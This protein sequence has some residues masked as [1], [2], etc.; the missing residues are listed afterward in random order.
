MSF[1]DAL[2]KHV[3]QQLGDAASGQLSDLVK[4][5]GKDVSEHYY[6]LRRE[7]DQLQKEQAATRDALAALCDE[8]GLGPLPEDKPPW[9][10]LRLRILPAIQRLRQR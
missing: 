3:G 5:V 6:Q 4:G 8:L 2:G 1:L 10:I 9:A 7:R